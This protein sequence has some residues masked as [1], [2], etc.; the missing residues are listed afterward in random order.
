MHLS[1]GVLPLAWALVNTAAVV[2]FVAKGARDI[3]RRAEDEP[4][5][6]PMMGLMGAAVF[7]ISA[8]PIPV[9]IAGT[10][11]HPT[12][13]GM[14]AIFL[15]PF[16]TVAI[17]GVVL[18]FQALLMAH[19]GVSTWG[20]NTLNM[21]VIGA[22]TG[23]WAF[24]LLVSVGLPVWVGAAAAGAVGDLATYGGT[25][26]SMAL[27]LHGDQSVWSVWLMV[28]GAFLPTQIPLAILE[29]VLTAGMLNFMLSRRPDIV[30]KLAVL[31][32]P[33]RAREGSVAG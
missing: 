28:F 25:A 18:L 4:A 8:L 33:K 21:G 1:E 14:A 23:Y 7:V 12:G 27:A 9:P 24:R 10:S 3:K 13:V 15:K 20:A 17:T 30:A 19:G 31:G 6:K 29:A 11:A 32:F 2:P 5:I 22:F 26:L 16:P